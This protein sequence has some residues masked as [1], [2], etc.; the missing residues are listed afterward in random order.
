MRDKLEVGPGAVG[1]VVLYSNSV[2]KLRAGQIALEFS[3]TYDQSTADAVVN[4]QTLFGLPPTGRTDKATW[5]V[6]D[7]L[8]NS[9]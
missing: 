5:D 8:A 9:E 3:S 4:V 6:I 1:E 2:L 7:T